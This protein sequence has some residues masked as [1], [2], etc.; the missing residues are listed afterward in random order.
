M[1]EIASLRRRRVEIEQLLE[2]VQQGTDR[3]PSPGAVRDAIQSLLQESERLIAELVE[4]R[5]SIGPLEERCRVVLS[6][7]HAV[8]PAAPATPARADHLGASTFLDRAWNAVA[9]CRYEDALVAAARALEHAP[10]D[11]QGRILQ[12]WALMRLNRLAEARAT[13]E[14]VLAEDPASAMARAT[15]GYV[16]FRQ[17]R[18]AEAIDHLSYASGPGEDRKAALYA[19]LYLGMCYTSRAMYRDGRSFLSRALELGPHLVEAYWEMG[20]SYYLE[21]QFSLALEA[22]RRG[23]EINRFNP[24]GDRCREAVDRAKAGGMVL[25][26]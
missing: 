6:A 14:A 23:A 3:V 5:E 2:R 1:T 9:T 22:W 17:G 24:W 4:L 25:L 10:G 26:D 16:A 7:R 15:L 8:A 18:F 12:G 19:N 21:G 11:P 13:L 20:R